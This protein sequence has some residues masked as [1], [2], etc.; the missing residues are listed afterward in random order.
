[1]IQMRQGYVAPH[2]SREQKDRVARLRPVEPMDY[3]SDPWVKPV[4]IC[5]GL[6][7][8]YF[9]AQYLRSWL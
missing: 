3:P 4:V 9:A 5:V 2:I 1:M 7:V 8:L 6:V